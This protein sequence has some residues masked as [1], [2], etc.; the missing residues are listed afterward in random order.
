MERQEKIQYLANIISLIRSD[1]KI[2]SQEQKL[3]FSVA[4][5]IG[6]GFLFLDQAEKLATSPNFKVAY[7]QRSSEALRLFEDML[8]LAHA[9]NQLAPEEGSLIRELLNHLHL[10]PAMVDRIKADVTERLKSIT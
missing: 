6:A 9:D 3:L 5:G 4:K 8:L 1:R 2:K 10:S 7:P